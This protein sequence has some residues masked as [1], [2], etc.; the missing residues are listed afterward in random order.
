[1]ESSLIL[2][3]SFLFLVTG[4]AHNISNKSLAMVDRTVTFDKL[5]ENPD[6]YSGKFVVFGGKIGAALKTPEGTVLEIIQHDLD[7][8]ELPDETIASR[9][10]FLA[11][12]PDSLNITMCRSSRLL[13]IAGVVAG[14]KV[15]QLKG[16]DYV[17]PL[18]NVRELHLFP[19]PDEDS[20]GVWVPYLP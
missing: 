15:Q 6:A 14:K 19:L 1:M 16:V 10:R 11:L 3:L 17:Y 13:S 5:L 12:T 4:C 2:A 20:F 8:R 9:G 7:G 18:I